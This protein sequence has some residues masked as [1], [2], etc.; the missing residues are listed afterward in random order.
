M[1]NGL[2]EEKKMKFEKILLFLEERYPKPTF[3]RHFAVTEDEERKLLD[4]LQEMEQR[5]LI[6][7]HFLISRMRD[8]AGL[9]VEAGNLLINEQGRKFLE[10]E[11]PQNSLTQNVTIHAGNGANVP[12][13]IAGRDVNVTQAIDP[14]QFLAVLIESVKKTNIPETEK[15]GLVQHAKSFFNATAPSVA[16]SIITET[17]KKI[18]GV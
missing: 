8:T 6:N 5:G 18:I 12:F 10:G 9:A 2:A 15:Q 17:I 1:R 14:E 4:T 16:S 7:G 13:N 3:L 11:T